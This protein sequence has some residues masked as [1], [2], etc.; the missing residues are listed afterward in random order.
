MDKYKIIVKGIVK[1]EDKY[2]MVKRWYDDRI[3]NPY[4]W[5]FIDGKIE[6]G[7]AP[8]KAVIRH[9]KENL[10]IEAVINRI[11]YTWSYM[12]GDVFH[13]GLCYECLGIQSEIILS[14][15]LHEYRF[16]MQDELDQ[17]IDNKDMLEDIKKAEM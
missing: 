6:F 17:Y 2:L 9:I 5:E 13:I 1:Y 8:E 12:V 7:E 11:L 14:E 4:Q 10:G 3:A 15:D 16:I